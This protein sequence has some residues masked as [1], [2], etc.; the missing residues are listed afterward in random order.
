MLEAAGLPAPRYG[1]A[2]SYDEAKAVADEI[3]Y[4]VLV[5]PSYVLGGR[6]MEIVYD[7]ATLEDY[8]GRAA[9]A[10]P[11]HPVLID[12]FL[13]DAIEIDVD[14]LYDGEELFLGGVMEHIEEAG[15]HSGDSACA[16]PPITLGR[17]DIARIRESTE[18][19]AR[20]VGV[21]GLLNVQYAMA[22]GV[23]HVLEANPRASRTVPFVSKA[24]ATPLAKAAARIMLGASVAD[25]RAEGMLPASG[26][27]GT[28]PLDA[29][30]AVKEAV[31]PFGRFRDA[32]GQG[33]DTVLGPE[34]RSTGEVM[35]IDE[36]FGT[37]YAKSQAAVYGPLPVK[38]RVFVSV[39]NRDKRSMV[40]PV[41]RL[42]DLG[43][44]IWATEGTCRG[45]AAQRRSCHD[46]PE[47][48]RRPRPGRRARYRGQDPRRAGGSHREHAVRQPRAVGSPAGRLRDPDRRGAAR[49]AL[50][51]HGPG[52]RRRGAGHRGHSARRGGGAIL[53]GVR[54][55]RPAGR[56]PGAG[57]GGQPRERRLAR[58]HRRAAP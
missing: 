40:F 58:E 57:P 39:A 13:D 21:R 37:A 51:H 41:K 54:S 26:D 36:V 46:R 22:A 42:A 35:G 19:I 44:E 27:G 1:T 10:S 18:A 11:G 24:T 20:G 6:G 28:L 47:A 53:A 16:L 34:M 3:G 56:P 52:T 49:G 31:L 15:I 29:P 55:A 2:L 30:I 14:A 5:R 43:F 48:Q 4:P 45:A 8:V 9:A 32:R 12:R 17:A 38:G 50:C 33:V 7:D 25:L 23:L